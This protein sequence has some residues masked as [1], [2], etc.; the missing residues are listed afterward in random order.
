MGAGGV[1]GRLRVEGVPVRDPARAP[2][3]AR[4][5]VDGDRHA[6][7][8][9]R[10]RVP[11]P[12]A[13]RRHRVPG[14]DER[15]RDL[16]PA[17]G[18]PRRLAP[19]HPRRGAALHGPRRVLREHEPHRRRRLVPVGAGPRHHQHR[20][21]GR[22]GDPAGDR[23]QELR[24]PAVLHVRRDRH[25]R[26]HPARAVPA[27][28]AGRVRRGDEPLLQRGRRPRG[29]LPVA[30]EGRRR[31]RRQPAAGNHPRGH[32]ARH[33]DRV[34]EPAVGHL[35]RAAGRRDQGR[36]RLQEPDVHHRRLDDRRGRR[37]S[38][39]S[40]GPRSAPSAPPSSTP[41]RTRTTTW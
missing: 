30:P 8:R 37:A 3:R 34:D 6:A 38:P 26:R 36:P 20:R 23:L 27:H 22:D 5:R 4:L 19:R 15:V 16:D 7:L 33:A 2:D 32:P 13:R 28:H 25:P 24:A 9:R 21:R 17:V 12:R 14:R 40:P 10:L 35:Q 11:E 31:R 18:R 29:L 41:C 1:P 39:S